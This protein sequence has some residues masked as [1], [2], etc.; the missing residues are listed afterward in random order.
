MTIW[1]AGVNN[2]DEFVQAVR[3]YFDKLEAVKPK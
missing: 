2:H 1:G 3:P